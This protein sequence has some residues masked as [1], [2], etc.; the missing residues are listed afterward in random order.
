MLAVAMEQKEKEEAID[1]PAYVVQESCRSLTINDL[2]IS[3]TLN[4]PYDLSNI[5]AHRIASSIEL[6]KLIKNGTVKFVR[7]EELEDYVDRAEEAFSTDDR[8]LQTYSNIGDAADD[9][10]RTR[11]DRDDDEEDDNDRPRRRSSGSRSIRQSR[12]TISDDDAMEITM[13]DNNDS[14]S[15]SI[16]D[17]T[18][19]MPRSRNANQSNQSR[20][21]GATRTSSHGS[22]QSNRQSNEDRTAGAIRRKI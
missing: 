18:N 14:D 12:P 8:G 9:I 17:L 10:G 22:N 5:S 1:I 11:A 15:D 19:S 7:P 20:P 6:K 16:L 13:D 3:L 21:N 4:V 2:N